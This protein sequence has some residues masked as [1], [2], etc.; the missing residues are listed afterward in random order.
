MAGVAGYS[1]SLDGVAETFQ[2]TASTMYGIY[3]AH[4]TQLQQEVNDFFSPAG[5]GARTKMR[6]FTM[7]GI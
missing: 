5:G 3:S 7:G 2:S 4:I 1:L 6:G